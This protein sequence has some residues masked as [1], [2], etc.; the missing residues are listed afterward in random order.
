MRILT[1]ATCFPDHYHPTMAPWS[2]RQVDAIKNYSN[3]DL[4]VVVPRPFSIPLKFVPHHEFAK[5]P[6]NE[7]SDQNYV[8]HYPRFPYLVPKRLFFGLTGDLYTYFVSKYILN[9]IKKADIIHARF[10]YLDGYGVLKI[11]KK[12]DAELVFDV[13]GTKD[14]EKGFT[15]FTEKKHRKTVNYAKKILCVAKWQ[16][17]K[18]LEVGISKDKL[19]CVPLGVNINKFKP[20]NKEKIRQEFGVEEK[21]IVLYVGQ[22]IKRKG[23]N[24]LLKAI[25]MIESSSRKDSKLVIIGGGPERNDLLK[26]SKELNLQDLVLFTGKVSEE[27]LLKWYSLA[28]IFVLPSLYEGRPTVINEAM[29]SECAVVATNVSG[30]PEQVKEGHNGFLVEPENAGMLAEK[31]NYLL[32]NENEMSR[33]EK[34]SRKRVIEEDWTWEGYAKKVMKIYEEVGG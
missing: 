33:M 5:L 4:E 32:N 13:H 23:I 20:R 27:D 16:V 25:S 1:V 15:P 31:I 19:E 2:K 11:C 26:M 7:T 14:F 22:L 8:I 6:L 34:N 29:A 24:Y 17:E 30:I 3:V 9:N 21:R 28:N 12:W 18:G 10:S